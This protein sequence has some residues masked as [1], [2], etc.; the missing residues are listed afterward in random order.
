MTVTD[1]R[2]VPG[3]SGFL[4]D[5]GTTAILYDTGFGFTGELMADKLQLL[6][7][8]RPLDYIFLTHSHYDHALGAANVA[9]RYPGV[10]IVAGRYAKGI[11]EKASARA[12]MR[13]LDQK[14]AQ[15][16]GMAGQPDLTG[17]LR[18]D[19]PVEGGDTVLCGSMEF[20]VIPLPG[21][22]R[23][24]IGF[25][26]AE[27]RLL[28][29]TET[30]GVYFGDGVCLPSYLVSYELTLGSFQRAMELEIDRI[31]LPHYG[32]I[33]GEEARS[34]LPFARQVAVDVAQMIRSL[35][36]SGKSHQETAELF[37]ERFYL[38]NVA[39]TYPIDA[40]KMNTD[41]MIRLL[42]QENTGDPS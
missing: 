8:E 11:F 20:T 7:G 25:Y 31:L 41:I 39:P 24:S 36:K 32:L 29:S 23:C 3:D 18:V 13:D 16:L 6:L 42:E 10:R 40:F 30:L 22:T 33:Q 4:I 28:L 9:K 17:E 14:A 38:P 2:I 15:S 34:Y 12:V 35:L 37:K 5:D 19:I 21:H 27:N 26:L 1:V